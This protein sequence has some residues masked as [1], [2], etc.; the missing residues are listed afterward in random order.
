MENRSA[1]R[2]V[3]RLLVPVLAVGTMSAGVLAVTSAPA[4]AAVA[5]TYACAYRTNISFFGGPYGTMGCGVQTGDGAGE[6]SA[7][8]SVQLPSTGGSLSGV[9]LNGARA[10]YFGVANM[11]SSPYDTADNTQN[12]GRLDVS[13]QGGSTAVRAIAKAETVGPSPFWTHS[14][15]YAG[16]WAAPAKTGWSSDGTVGFVRSQC[17]GASDGNEMGSGRVNNGY[18]DT[19]TGSDGYPTETVAVP[20]PTP[21]NYRINFVMHNT[22]DTGYIVFN[23]R[24]QNADGTLTVNGAHMYMQ[25]PSAVGDMVIAQTVCGIS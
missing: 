14:P 16:P 21:P 8:P 6:N 3:K 25:G 5:N 4:Q 1:R 19:I 18:V 11:F 17:D 2:R 13:A 9:D 10:L 20:D 24:I 22:N 7:A 23:E 12:S 15:G